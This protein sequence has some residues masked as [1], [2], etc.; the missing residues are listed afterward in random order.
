[1][2]MSKALGYSFS[3]EELRRGIYYP[4]GRVKLEQSQTAVLDGLR[5]ALEGKAPIPMKITEFPTSPELLAAQIALTEN[6]A[7]AYGED[8]A[9]KVRIQGDVSGIRAKPGR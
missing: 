4:Q 6:S 5:M 7:K 9:L 1:M 3:D 8:G 2:A